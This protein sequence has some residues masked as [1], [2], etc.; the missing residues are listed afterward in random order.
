MRPDLDRAS[1]NQRA[2]PVIGRAKVDV[3]RAH[4]TKTD[5]V[6]PVVRVIVMAIVRA[7]ILWIVVPRAPAQHAR[8]ENGTPRR[9]P[10]RGGIA[11]G[12]RKNC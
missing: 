7:G 6:V 9:L 2:V 11:E 4:H 8:L 1:R 5:V 3:G 12:G 10:D